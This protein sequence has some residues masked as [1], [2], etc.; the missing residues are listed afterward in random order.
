MPKAATGS[1]TYHWARP[2]TPEEVRRQLIKLSFELEN[3]QEP[4]MVAGEL[5][6]IDIQERFKEGNDPRGV[7]WKAWAESYEPW[8]TAHTTGPIFGDRANL[9][10]T[11]ATQEAINQRS[12]F[13]G[14]NQGLFL[15]TSGLPEYAMWNNFGAMRTQ[16]SGGASSSRETRLSNLAFRREEEAVP[17]LRLSGENQLFP[18]P[19]L[20]ISDS[21]SYKMD[22]AFYAWFDGEVAFATSGRGKPFFRHAKRVGGMGPT[23]TRFAPLD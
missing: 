21:A 23:R 1:I 4:M 18:R 9:H 2:N 19:F 12:A 15:D 7:P 22:A 20:G 11:G 13:V 5:A 8:A 14:T 3:L 16:A 17:G 10:L 6:R